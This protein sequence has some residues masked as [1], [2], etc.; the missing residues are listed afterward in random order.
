MLAPS[1]KRGPNDHVTEVKYHGA[2]LTEG[3]WTAVGAVHPDAVAHVCGAA[4]QVCR[5][6]TAWT[7]R[8]RTSASFSL[9]TLPCR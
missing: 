6:L 7:H 9:D 8:L 1:T 4:P 5:G 2:G 3:S